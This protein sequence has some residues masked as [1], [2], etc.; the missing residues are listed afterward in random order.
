MGPGNYPVPLYIYGRLSLC[1]QTLTSNA[2]MMIDDLIMTSNSTSKTHEWH[3][4]QVCL[5][6][7]ESIIQTVRELVLVD[8]ISEYILIFDIWYTHPVKCVYQSLYTYIIYID[9]IVNLL[10]RNWQISIIKKNCFCIF[11][12]SCWLQI[13]P[14]FSQIP[15]Q[16]WGSESVMYQWLGLVIATD[17][18]C[19]SPQN[20]GDVFR[21]PP[22][23][24]T[25]YQDLGIT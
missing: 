2:W 8:L 7:Q 25:K 15:L 16:N 6:G 9:L 18:P 23:I 3:M 5:E 20:D 11:F 12:R 17:L 24:D 10:W 4:V 21:N 1:E 19:W 14:V 13:Q 22:E